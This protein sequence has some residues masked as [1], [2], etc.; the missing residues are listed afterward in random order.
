MLQTSSAPTGTGFEIRFRSLFQDDRALT[1]ACNREG[2]VDL[3]AMSERA[4]NNYFFARA[5]IG[6]EYALPVVKRSDVGRELK[7]PCEPQAA[8]TGP[9][10]LRQS[11]TIP[12]RTESGESSCAPSIRIPVKVSANDGYGASKSTV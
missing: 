5:T 10:V 8:S 3:D 7:F 2:R 12:A 6:L 11:M 4:R 9:V 1:F